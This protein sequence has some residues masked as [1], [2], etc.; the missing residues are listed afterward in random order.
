MILHI[1]K[2]YNKSPD[3]NI[4]VLK[5]DMLKEQGTHMFLASYTWEQI[6][7]ELHPGLEFWYLHYL[8]SV[9]SD[10]RVKTIETDLSPYVQHLA[11]LYPDKSGL[12]RKCIMQ[13]QPLSPVLGD[14]LQVI[15]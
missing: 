7:I 8:P 1:N 3:M 12:I 13:K 9:C 15:K 10:I 5:S 6:V 14:K 2:E 11:E 4:M